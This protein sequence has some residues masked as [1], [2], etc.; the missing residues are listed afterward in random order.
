[1]SVLPPSLPPP[2]GPIFTK[3]AIFRTNLGFGQHQDLVHILETFSF[4]CKQRWFGNNEKSFEIT[5]KKPI[6]HVEHMPEQRYK[7][8]VTVSIKNDT[9]GSNF[10]CQV[11]FCKVQLACLIRSRFIAVSK[12][13]LYRF[14]W[15]LFQS[16]SIEWSTWS[17]YSHLFYS[18]DSPG[19]S[20][21]SITVSTF[22]SFRDFHFSQ[23][24][25]Q[26]QVCV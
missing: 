22:S 6:L 24:E 5:S 8:C 7:S 21:E 9:H 19:V 4:K 2:P 10:I 17:M 12:C 20:T 16:E 26:C 11:R 1:M 13:I 25:N 15:Y 23:T 18:G 3:P 14:R